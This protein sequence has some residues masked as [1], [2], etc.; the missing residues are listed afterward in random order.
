[1]LFLIYDI[2]YFCFDTMWM[3]LNYPPVRFLD[4]ASPR[5]CT[6][7]RFLE[8]MAPCLPQL[9]LTTHCTVCFMVSHECVGLGWVTWAGKPA[10]W[11]YSLESFVAAVATPSNPSTS[12]SDDTRREESLFVFSIEYLYL[13]VVRYIGVGRDRKDQD[14]DG[15]I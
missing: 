12:S 3:F 10:K 6:Q 1:M 2:P 4:S 14:S 11:G 9:A 7:L 15:N 8:E 13:C 5:L